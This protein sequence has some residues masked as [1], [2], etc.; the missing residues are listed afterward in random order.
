MSQ[1]ASDAKIQS[2]MTKLGMT[3]PLTNMDDSQVLKA[4]LVALGNV[5]GGSA[6][7][8]SNVQLGL[9]TLTYASSVALD[10][11]GAGFASV[12][13]AGNIEFTT[14]NLA[15]V[16]SKTVRIIA[17]GST[18]NF[19]FPAGWTFVGA[20]APASIDANLTGILTLSS[21]GTTDADVVAAYAVES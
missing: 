16:R 1:I 14:S 3:A 8:F 2:A 15:A 4:I 20:A 21:F 17:D 5:Q 19:T 12:T 9:E 18:R 7:A 6:P 13:L 10:F 11:V